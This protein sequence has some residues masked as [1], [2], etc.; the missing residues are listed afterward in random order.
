MKLIQTV[1]LASASASIELAS[2]PQ[3]FTDLVLLISARGDGGNVE[4]Y[5]YP[6]NISN[7]AGT[8]KLLSNS[9]NIGSAGTQIIASTISSDTANTFS[10]TRIYIPNYTSTLSKIMCTDGVTENNA[11]SAFRQLG[12]VTWTLTDPITSLKVEQT[13]TLNFVAG[14]TISLYGILK[15]SDG[16]TTAS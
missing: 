11:A 2:I 4:P 15:G 14:T 10:N 13:A 8:R 16:I 6:N 5:V 12:A 9:N 1:T 7:T 3:S